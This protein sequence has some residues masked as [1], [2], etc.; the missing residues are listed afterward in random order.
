MD[1]EENVFDWNAILQMKRFPRLGTLGLQ[2]CPH[3]AEN[4]LQVSRRGFLRVAEAPWESFWWEGDVSQG[5]IIENF[6]WAGDVNSALRVVCFEYDLPVSFV[7]TPREL[8]G[9]RLTHYDD[10]LRA[11]RDQQRPWCEM[12]EYRDPTQTEQVGKI[13]I[14]GKCRYYFELTSTGTSPLFAILVTPRLG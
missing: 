9:D 8:L 10:V 6:V 13:I 5:P 11:V 12:P 3:V 7:H 2:V 14:Q 1:D 4:L